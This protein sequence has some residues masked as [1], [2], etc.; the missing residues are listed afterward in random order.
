VA[1][2]VIDLRFA[3]VI[4]L[5]A[6]MIAVS[7]DSG[8]NAAE[9]ADLTHSAYRPALVVIASTSQ[10]QSTVLATDAEETTPATVRRLHHSRMTSAIMTSS[11][12]TKA[13]F[14]TDLPTEE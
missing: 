9:A 8:G 14:F 13:H 7:V 6:F 1:R 5:L 2:Q 11:R 10:P 12:M 3:C 4:G